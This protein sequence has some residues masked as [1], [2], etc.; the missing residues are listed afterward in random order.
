M[1]LNLLTGYVAEVALY[2]TRPPPFGGLTTI[3]SF[4]E[5]PAQT[6]EL[7]YSPQPGAPRSTVKTAPRPCLIF[8]SPV[9]I[10]PSLT[11]I[12]LNRQLCGFDSAARRRQKHN[13]VKASIARATMR[14]TAVT[15]TFLI[16]A[17]SDVVSSKAALPELNADITN[18]CHCD[19]L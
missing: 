1:L 7:K 14:S 2:Q 15:S 10:L 8:T 19:E 4:R 17:S 18:H 6:G 16:T 3:S 9:G 5:Q 11:R 13:I 12:F